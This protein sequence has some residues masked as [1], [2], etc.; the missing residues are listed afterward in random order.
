MF[1]TA[2]GPNRVFFTWRLRSSDLCRVRD[3]KQRRHD[4]VS[5]SRRGRIEELK[6]IRASKERGAGGD[7]SGRKR[8]KGRAGR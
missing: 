1:R 8:E 4:D 7:R 6:E 2:R 5:E 3:I